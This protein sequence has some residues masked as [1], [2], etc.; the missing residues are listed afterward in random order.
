MIINNEMA[1]R[2]FAFAIDDLEKAINYCPDELWEGRLWEDEP[3]QWVAK[4]FGTF[5]YL[6][7]HALFWLD[8][9]LTGSE[10][11][12]RP[13]APFDLIEMQADE[14]LP[15]TYHREELLDYVKHCRRRCE[16]T[17]LELSEG[18]ARRMCEFAWGRVPFGELLLYTMR[19]VQEHAAQLHLFLSQRG[20]NRA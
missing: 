1:W 9:Y 20:A 7:Y 17:I 5:W 15:R 8:L 13:P 2:Q 14:T 4:G 18:G 16:E 12:F 19:H 10:E 11:G 6:G 3:G